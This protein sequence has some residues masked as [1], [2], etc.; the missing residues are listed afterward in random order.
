MAA[1][2]FD[3]TLMDWDALS[4]NFTSIAKLVAKC[5]P[6]TNLDDIAAVYLGQIL[7]DLL[8]PKNVPFAAAADGVTVDPVEHIQAQF[9]AKGLA[10]PNGKFLLILLKLAKQFGPILLPLLLTENP[11]A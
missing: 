5:T 11:T 10:A 7:A 9:A 4:A 2:D 8:K 1:L 6:D 3:L